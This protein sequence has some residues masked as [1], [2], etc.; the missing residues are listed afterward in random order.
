MK[1]IICTVCPQGCEIEVEEVNGELHVSNN[2]CP[3]GEA[4][5]KSEYVHPV[6]L[7]TSLVR[8]EGGREPLV[9]VRSTKPIPKEQQRACVDALR[10]I[11]LQAPVARYTLVLPNVFDSGAD[12]VTSG[13]VE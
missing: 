4:Y 8:V 10:Q 13:T 1:R 3:R 9:P 7:F 2:G 12:I 5:G 11:T 6:R